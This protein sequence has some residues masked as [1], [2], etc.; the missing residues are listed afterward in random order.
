MPTAQDLIRLLDLQ[1]LPREGGYFRSTYRSGDRLPAAALPSRYSHDHVSG[2]AIYYL[3]TPDTHSALH[4]LATDEIYHFYAGDPVQMLQ[5]FE[6]GQGRLVTLGPDV[7][8]GQYPQ[9]AVPRGVWQGSMLLPGGTYALLGTTM[10]PGFE[11]AD[12]ELGDQHELMRR[13]PD[14]ANLIRRLGYT[15]RVPE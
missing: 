11:E 10:A 13:Y 15:S 7:L 5:L 9:L 12:F 3:L 14:Y 1:P 6:D 2:S 4:R 8:A